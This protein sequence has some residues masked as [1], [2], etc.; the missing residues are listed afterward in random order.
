MTRQLPPQILKASGLGGVT[1]R[2]HVGQA[3]RT[4]MIEFVANDPGAG[5]NTAT[6]A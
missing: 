2:L 4:R 5:V 6:G 3:S 1:S